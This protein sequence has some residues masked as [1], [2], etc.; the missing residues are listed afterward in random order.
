[1]SRNPD[2]RVDVGPA[3]VTDFERERLDWQRRLYAAED[4]AARLL[5][6]KH[7]A[8][9][10][11]KQQ[12]AQLEA[13]VT[14]LRERLN[15]SSARFAGRP[16]AGSEASRANREHDDDPFGHVIRQASKGKHARVRRKA[17]QHVLLIVLVILALALAAVLVWQGYKNRSLWKINPLAQRFEW[18]GTPRNHSAEA[19]ACGATT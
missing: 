8:E 19:S 5:R 17:R 1:M 9:Q 16:P 11:L 3:A 2:E 14:R 6:E 4:L 18:F 12:I 13:E 10:S 7:E 15:D